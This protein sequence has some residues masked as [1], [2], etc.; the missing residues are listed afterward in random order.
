MGVCSTFKNVVDSF[1]AHKGHRENFGETES[2]P[3]MTLGMLVAILLWIALVL[4]VG[5][6]LWNEVA[7]RYTTICKPMP[8]LLP[9]LGLVILMDILFPNMA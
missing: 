3:G 8:S 9:L 2:V 1:V 5:K 7:C 4:F 6:V